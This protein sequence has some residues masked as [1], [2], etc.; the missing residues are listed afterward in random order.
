[1]LVKKIGLALT[2]TT[3][4][5]TSAAAAT[6]NVAIDSSPAGLDPHLITAFN[7]VVIV[8]GNVYEGLTDI[9]AGLN[10]VPDLAA[11]WDISAD[12]LSYTFK[13][14]S[15]VTFHDGSTMD[16]EDVAASIRRVQA[17]KTASPMA[18]SVMPITNIEIIDP[19]TIKLSLDE[20]FAPILS[21]LATI[22]IVPAELEA[23]IE[24]L[25]QKPVGTGP[26]KF[27]EWLPNNYIALEK[28]E[29][30]REAGLPMLD[31]VKFNFVPEASTRQVGLTSGDYGILPGIDP[32][33]ALQLQA[34]P[35]VKLHDTLNVSY[36]LLGMNVTRGPLG[37]AKVRE[38]VNMLLNRDEIIAGALFGA[39]VPG[40][41]L[42]PALSAWALDTSEFA[43]YTTNVDGAKALLAEAG[44]ETPIKLSILVLPRQDAR[45]ISQ[46]IQQQLAAGG[47]EVDLV[48]K[49]IGEF[50]QDWRNSNFDM[51]VSANGGNPDPDQYFYRTF[52]SGGP[53][54]VYKY[55][56]AEI[57][58]LLDTGR[59]E[60]DQ[61]KRK[62]AY[63]AAQRTLACQGP[64][65]HLAYGNLF[66]ATNAKV[67]GFEIYPT[68]RLTSLVNVSLDE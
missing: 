4:L 41:P 29:G 30:Y 17:E 33:T 66:T 32:A 57:D 45:D 18:A 60:T 23:D 39:G 28:F 38:A 54:N 31:G 47:I 68:G 46:V 5:V 11:S 22:A 15:G 14:Q 43:C 56:N 21:S 52:R 13:L 7:S 37:D 58:T 27:V 16:A 42:S 67:K 3:F 25:Q 61:A 10:V 49:E 26:F 50:V 53:T 40:G 9:D 62:Q 63:D 19:L 20:P 48:N 24:A 36:T 64:I 55:A 51:F 1:M 34:Q 35:G 8:Q 44:I 2:T 12:N 59:T 6:L 65:A